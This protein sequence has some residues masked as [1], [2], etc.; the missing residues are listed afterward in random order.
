MAGDE[1][2]LDA[3]SVINLAASGIWEA[4]LN[5]NGMTG[6]VVE[7][8]AAE[9]IRVADPAPERDP[10]PV[11][12]ESL[13]AR[14]AV[15]IER[16][17]HEEVETWVSLASELGDGEAASLAVAAN[18]NWALAT[19]DRKARIAHARLV[20]SGT[21]WSTSQLVRRWAEISRVQPENV[22]SVLD[23]I[24]RLGRFRPNNHDPE[25]DW[26][27]TTVNARRIA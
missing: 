14:G 4:V 21:L 12:L 27:R 24:E 26:W 23:R 5:T 25:H 6:I 8:V 3:C 16:L 19:D 13:V 10:Q 20:P 7:A 2:L 18:R 17:T 1:L 11:D 22:A 15:R 9:T